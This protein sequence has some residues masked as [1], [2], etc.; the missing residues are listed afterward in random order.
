MGK[1][2]A[3]RGRGRGC[4]GKRIARRGKSLRDWGGNW[5]GGKGWGKDGGRRLWGR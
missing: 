1:R 3:R 2:V 5:K 4:M